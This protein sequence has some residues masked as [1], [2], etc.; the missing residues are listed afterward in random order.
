MIAYIWRSDLCKV[1]I[2]LFYSVVKCQRTRALACRFYC[3]TRAFDRMPS[4]LMSHNAGATAHTSH[5]LAMKCS[6]C[7]WRVRIYQTPFNVVH[8]VVVC[9][10]SG[11]DLSAERASMTCCWHYLFP[12][13]Y[14]PSI[15]VTPVRV[16]DINSISNKA[17][18]LNVLNKYLISEKKNWI[19][20][21][22]NTGRL[23]NYKPGM[24]FLLTFVMTIWWQK[25]TTWKLFAR[26]PSL[27]DN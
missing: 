6:C 27:C 4:I 9:S 11:H 24:P 26:Q 18:R 7:V 14:K 19:R 8:F 3:Q 10:G 25:P 17:Y 1:V 5:I 16:L 20:T 15:I 2:F 21:L 13:I 12:S 22:I 23:Y